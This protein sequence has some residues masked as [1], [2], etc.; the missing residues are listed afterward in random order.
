[1]LQ[2]FRNT[3]LAFLQ[4]LPHNDPL[5]PHESSLM[6]TA[7][8]LLKIENEENALLCI[9]IIIDGFRSHK[10]QTEQ[11]VQPFLNLV[12]EMYANIK[13]VVEKEFGKPEAEVSLGVLG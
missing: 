12:K 4:R 9:K 1:M 11:H 2:R 13:Q 10:E 5:K 6:S 7:L 3:L 8:A